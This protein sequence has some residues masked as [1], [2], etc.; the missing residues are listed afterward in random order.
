MQHVNS[1]YRTQLTKN[2]AFR[3]TNMKKLIFIFFIVAMA[4]GGLFAENLYESFGGAFPPAGWSI[5]NGLSAPTWERTSAF[6]HS[7]SGCAY[8]SSYGTSYIFYDD[9]LITPQLIPKPGASTFSFYS[10]NNSTL[11]PVFSLKLSTTTNAKESFATTIA[12]NVTTSHSWTQ[13]T[14]NLSAWNGQNIYLAFHDLYTYDDWDQ[15]HEPNGGYIYVDDVQGP[16]L[17]CLEGFESGNFNTFNWTNSSPSPWTVQSTE[18][19]SGIYAAKSG[20][21]GDNAITRLSIEQ[22]GSLGGNITFWQKVSSEADGDF[23]KFFIDGEEQGAWSGETAWAQ[24]SY[25][26][27]AGNHTYL[28]IYTT[29]ESGSSGSNCAWVDNITLPSSVPGT[30]ASPYL[31]YTA[32]DLNNVRY[33]LGTSYAGKYFK[34]MNDIDLTSYLASGGAGYT[35]WGTNGWLP[36]G[37][38][39]NYFYGNFDGNNHTISNLRIGYYGTYHGLFGVTAVGSTI[40][41]LKLASNCYYLGNG[42][43]GSIVGNNKGLVQNCSS[44]ATVNIGNANIGGGIVGNNLGTITGCKFTGTIT[45]SGSGVSCNKIGGVAG[46]NETGASILESSSTGSVS[47]NTW[48][49]GLV[50]WNNGT[51]NRCFTTGTI[52]GAA[53]SIG[54]LVGQHQGTITN[55]YSR[56]AVSG[57]SAIGGLVGYNTGSTITNCF[58]T[59]TVTGGQKGGLCGQSG[60]TITSSYWDTQTSGIATSYGGT[61]KTS[62]EMKT[63]TT[64]SGWDFTGETTNGSNDY[65]GIYSSVFDGYPCLM[66]YCSSFT[67]PPVLVYPANGASGISRYRPY[68]T[69]TNDS[70]GML[71]VRYTLYMVANAP[72]HLMDTGYFNQVTYSMDYN[73]YWAG[74]DFWAI[75]GVQ[76]ISSDVW[77]W[78][79]LA[80]NALGEAS[81]SPTYSFTLERDP[82]ETES[83]EHSNTD[84]STAISSWQQNWWGGTYESQTYW[85]ANSTHTDFNRAPRTGAYNVT[86]FNSGYPIVGTALTHVVQFVAGST[87]EIEL[88]ARQDTANPSDAYIRFWQCL[89]N[90][91]QY[92]PLSPAFGL[93]N[94]AYQRISY[95][96]TA[97]SRIATFL[98]IDGELSDN[99]NYI[100]MDDIT[101]REVLVLAAPEVSIAR[102]G[103]EVTLCWNEVTN[104]T[105]YRV[106]ASD[107]PDSWG[108]YTI[109]TAPTHTYT[110]NAANLPNKFFK[111]VAASAASRNDIEPLKLKSKD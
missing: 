90:P 101:V 94:G 47:G 33:F 41:N 23:Q 75:S 78:K 22:S 109:V 19:Q 62:A 77:Y 58:S 87:Y 80:Y 89:E 99:A 5:I 16:Q 73:P 10:L 13:Y 61:G 81:V 111:V 11:N 1:D 39:S 53:N 7:N 51:I 72:E 93:T 67:L 34:L 14:Y 68:V 108:N 24:R 25:P 6:G 31:I 98:I 44:A 4:I 15:I 49:G 66:W 74:C 37:D 20:T 9:W 79:V 35:A 96:F 48:C 28:W 86:L 36:I 105:E 30:A 110:I 12:A 2:D 106:Y 3:S 42:D 32:A 45:R 29:N 107:F 92:L 91:I 70:I 21:I 69:W 84:G 104:A 76:L 83:F 17:A 40:K 38:G 27:S 102:S 26:V 64:Y 52:T 88:Y 71:P 46:N 103:N 18:K 85:Q 54:G 100:S 60:A 57:A 50:G 63:Q 65:W 43:T 8:T 56:A 59:G 55:S 97:P 95:T 82:W